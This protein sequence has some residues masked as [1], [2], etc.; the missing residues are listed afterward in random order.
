MII[1]LDEMPIVELPKVASSLFLNNH[2]V[3]REAHARADLT[4]MINTPPD[5]FH[6]VE[7]FGGRILL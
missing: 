6:T 3:R 5:V 1:G 2:W 4:N 7:E